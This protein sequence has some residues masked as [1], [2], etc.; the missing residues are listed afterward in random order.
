LFLY[1]GDEIIEQSSGVVNVSPV[2]GIVMRAPLSPAAAAADSTSQGKS[3]GKLIA[4][5]SF[6]LQGVLSSTERRS[7]YRIKQLLYYCNSKDPGAVLAPKF[8]GWGIRLYR[9]RCYIRH[10]L[11]YLLP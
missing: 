2:S 10:L 6:S 3:T 11:T 1:T 7:Q 4:A 9:L 8:W 5:A